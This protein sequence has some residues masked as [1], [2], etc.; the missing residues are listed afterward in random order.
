M[1]ALLTILLFDL[2]D[3]DD[4]RVLNLGPLAI[5]VF[6]LLAAALGGWVL[7][8]AVISLPGRWAATQ[9]AGVYILLSLV[10]LVVV[11]PLTDFLLQIEHLA[12]RAGRESQIHLPLVGIDWPLAPILAAL[13]LDRVVHRARQAGQE[14]HL[15][16]MWKRVAVC[17]VP[18]PI[19][20]PVGL[21]ALLYTTGIENNPVLG[22]VGAVLSLLLGLVGAWAG[23]RYGQIMGD[24]LSTLEG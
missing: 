20:L 5:N 7:V 15:S 9:V 21:L 14:P 16:Q 11:P 1:L 12:Y 18:V 10:V 2:M 8:A 6:P 13:L 22:V 4:L 17:A 23:S 24:A 19:L 3:S